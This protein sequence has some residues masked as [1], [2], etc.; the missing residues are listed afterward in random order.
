MTKVFVHGNPETAAIWGP[1]IEA[2]S[3]WGFSDMV[4]VS[5]PGFGAPVPAGFGAHPD[6]YVAWL[7][8]EIRTLPGPIDLVGHDWGTG[9]VMG[10]AAAH[11]ELIRSWATDIGGLLHP[12]YVAT[13]DAAI[14]ASHRQLPRAADRLALWALG[15]VPWAG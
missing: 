2:L 5:P 8:D 7:A 12:D 11:P 4:T 9:H 3:G 15:E 1:L 13:L 14:A 6:D 10:V